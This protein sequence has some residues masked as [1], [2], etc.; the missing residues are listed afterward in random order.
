MATTIHIIRLNSGIPDAAIRAEVKANGRA[1]IEWENL[2]IRKY[3]DNLSIAAF[4][5]PFHFL[6]S[7]QAHTIE[8]LNQTYR[9]ITTPV[10]KVK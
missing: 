5:I 6:L 4:I 3:T 10:L 8:N 7:G 1:N 2:I 9:Y